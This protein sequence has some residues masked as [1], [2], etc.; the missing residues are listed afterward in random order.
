MIVGKP[1]PMNCMENST[2]NDLFC[3]FSNKAFSA[4][5]QLAHLKIIGMSKIICLHCIGVLFVWVKMWMVT[6]LL[7]NMNT[8]DRIKCVVAIFLLELN[9]F[10]KI[11]WSLKRVTDL[12]TINQSEQALYQQKAEK[13]SFHVKSVSYE[14]NSFFIFKTEVESMG[15]VSARN[16]FWLLKHSYMHAISK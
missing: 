9:R 8:I 10:W 2:K 1:T 3:P 16:H 6:A 12:P 5:K 11:R 13:P 14:L 7:T 15:S 4:Q